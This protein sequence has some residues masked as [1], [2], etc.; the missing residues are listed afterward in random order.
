MH[1]LK[2]ISLPQST[3]EITLGRWIDFTDSEGSTAID[4]QLKEATEL[5]GKR[6]DVRLTSIFVEQAYNTLAF[7]N[8]MPVEVLHK[9]VTVEGATELYTPFSKMV[10][11]MQKVDIGLW[12]LPAPVLSPQSDITFGQFIDS[13][14]ITQ[15]LNQQS[16]SKWRL[17]QYVCAIY[18]LRP[19]EKYNESF[20]D[21]TSA[22]FTYMSQ[23]TL[24]KAITVMLFYEEL[25]AFIEE[26]FSLFHATGE[27]SGHHMKQHFEQWG[28]VNFLK[29][30]AKTKI[31]DIPDSGMNSI[32][33]A[34]QTKLFEVLI[35]ASEDKDY[36]V[37]Y[38]RDMKESFT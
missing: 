28:W 20:A 23:L 25:N 22:R 37:A 24:D 14:I 6:K 36:N 26:N 5:K 15:A 31:F 11:T 18:L 1:D 4:A 16:Q 9:G 12:K 38:N 35:Y 17:L 34:R 29:S 19:D 8:G 27:K 13:K 10:H 33:C 3:S 2:N 21:D 30:I 32:D 7:F